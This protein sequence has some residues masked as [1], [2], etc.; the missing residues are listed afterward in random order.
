MLSSS[1]YKFNHVDKK[2]QRILVITNKN[3]LNITPQKFIN[4]IFAKMISSV[5]IKRKIPLYKIF[6]VTVSRFGYEFVIHVPDEYDY[7][8]RSDD[9]RERILECLCDAYL[10]FNKKKLGFFYKVYL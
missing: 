7:R 8:F 3:I 2:Q 6:A 4:N 9:F 1:T 5:R 10:S